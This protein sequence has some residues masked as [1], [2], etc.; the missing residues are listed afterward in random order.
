MKKTIVF[1]LSSIL[2]LSLVSACGSNDAD[3]EPSE[4]TAPVTSEP[5]EPAEP[6]TSEVTLD[7]GSVTVY[8]YGT[9]KLHAY[10]SGDALND[11]AYIVEG[12]DSL[13]G[14]ELPSFTDG[15]DAWQSYIGTLDKPMNDIF[16]CD[17]VT[18]ASYVADMT[19]LGTQ[20]AKDSIESGS[21]YAT[22]QGLPPKG[23]MRHSAR[24]STAGLNSRTSAKSCPALSLWP[25]SSST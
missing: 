12:T 11:V 14:I 9:V 6:V 19:V 17:H 22:T 2:L 3:S 7:A 23:Y 1:L 25:G 20:G 10:L 5:S 16:L 4:Q 15:L 18:G 21:T 24:I 8:D 13:V